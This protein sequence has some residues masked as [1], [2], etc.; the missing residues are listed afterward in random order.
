MTQTRRTRSKPAVGWASHWRRRGGVL[1]LA[2]G[3]PPRRRA[4]TCQGDR[5]PRPAT[6]RIT[7]TRAAWCPRLRL[8]RGRRHRESDRLRIR[9]DDG[10]YPGCSSSPATS[11]TAR[12]CIPIGSGSPTNLACLAVAQRGFGKSP[13]RPDFAGG[14]R[15]HRRLG[16]AS[17]LQ[18]GAHVD[19]SGWALR[20]LAF[21]VAASSWPCGS[22]PPASSRGVLGPGST[23]S[24]GVQGNQGP[25]IRE[26]MER[27][28]ATLRHAAAVR[29][30]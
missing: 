26:N 27:E 22:S 11:K 28:A 23:I 1:I 24:K 3:A 18:P 29:T 19:A 20:V 6:A 2:P 12:D 8:R 13:A 4:W 25:G 10:K 9:A 17:A 16:R 15:T 7:L 5:S 14:P 30:S 21:A